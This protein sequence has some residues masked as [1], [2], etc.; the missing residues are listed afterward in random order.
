MKHVVGLV[1]ALLLLVSVPSVHAQG[2]GISLSVVPP[3]GEIPYAG[4]GTATAT[5]TYGC[6]DALQ[7]GHPVLSAPEAP[8]WLVVTAGEIHAEPSENPT[9]CLNPSGSIAVQVPVTL[10]VSPNAPGVVPQTVTLQVTGNGKTATADVTFTVAYNADFEMTTDVSFPL[11]VTGPTVTFNLT[12]TQKSNARSMVMMEEKAESA[13]VLSGL[14]ST[15][16]EA[17]ALTKVFPVTYKAPTGTW[18]N[19]TV[20]FTAYSHWLLAE[21]GAGDFTGAQKVTW[22]FVNAGETHE[23]HDEPKKKSPAPVAP[24][25]AL[26]LLALAAFARRR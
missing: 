1:A 22:Q 23:E 19:A 9:A 7:D 10:E 24:L 4:S 15:V 25:L 21:G 12:V 2:Q 18:T 26:G 5:V 17:D 6:F 8:A 16:Y 14:S 3:A 20:T 11:N 13:G